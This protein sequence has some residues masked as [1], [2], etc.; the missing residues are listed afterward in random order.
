MLPELGTWH[1]WLHGQVVCVNWQPSNTLQNSTP[2]YAIQKSQKHHSRS[3]LSWNTHQDFLKIPSLWEAALE[4]K[5]RCFSNVIL[6]S[7]VTPNITRSSD[8]F[9]TVLPIV[10]MGDWG[11][12]V[13]DLKTY[14][15]LGLTRIQFHSPKVTPLA[16]TAK[17]MDLG[18]CYCNSNTR[19]WHNSHQIR[20]QHNWSAYFSKWKKNNSKVYRRSNSRP[21]T[22][23]CS[24]PETS[25]SLLWQP[26]TI[27]WCNWFDGNCVSI[28]YN[29]PSIPTEQSLLR[30]PWWLTLSK[31]ALKSICTLLV[32]CPLPNALCSVWDMHKSASQVLRPLW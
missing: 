22:L 2:T 9:T 12:I 27:T 16:R 13:H 19:R 31:A 17:V 20:H 11:C 4:T 14:H 3:D 32:S 7:Y 21:K 10:N 24:N 28:D 18:F 1:H 30:I 26:S 25:T 15:S 6:E 8:S 23:P 29:E 5:Q